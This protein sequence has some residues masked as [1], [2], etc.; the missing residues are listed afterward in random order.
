MTAM[1][2]RVSYEQDAEA[3]FEFELPTQLDDDEFF[4]PNIVRGRE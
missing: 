2:D 1:R 4:E 3:N